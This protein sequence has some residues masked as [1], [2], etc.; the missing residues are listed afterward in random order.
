MSHCNRV[1][2]APKAEIFTLWPFQKFAD[3]RF[4]KLVPEAYLKCLVVTSLYC[5][6]GIPVLDQLPEQSFLSLQQTLESGGYRNHPRKHPQTRY[7]RTSCTVSWLRIRRSCRNW[8]IL[9]DPAPI[10]NTRSFSMAHFPQKQE[11]VQCSAVMMTGARSYLSFFLCFCPLPLLL[12]IAQSP[13]GVT[14]PIREI[15]IGL[16]RGHC[17]LN[18]AFWS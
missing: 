6:F 9:Q 15:P 1:Y 3:S 7:P 10:N 8:K 4:N 14:T 11:C 13:S 18:R 2:L 5:C 17:S 16:V 12:S